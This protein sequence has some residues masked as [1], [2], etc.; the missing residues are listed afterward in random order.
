MA[1]RRANGEGTIYRRKDGRW[2]GA[3]YLL[4]T[5]GASKRIRIYGTSRSGVYAK[6]TEAKAK[7][8]QGIA[9]PDKVWQLGEYL[10]YW[11]E[12]IIKPH[13]RPTTYESYENKVRLYLKPTL[14]HYLLNRTSVP[15]LQSYLNSQLANGLSVRVVQMLREVLS[16]AL[17]SAMRQELVNRNVARLVQLPSRASS[18]VTPWTLNQATHFLK[19]AKGHWLYPAFVLLVIYGLRRGEVLGV[20]WTDIHFEHD[21]LHLEQQ[22]YRAN[23]IV[24]EGP[25]KTKSSRRKLPLVGIARD[26]LLAHQQDVGASQSHLVFTAQKSDGPIEPQTFTRSFQR[27]CKNAGL[28]ATGPHAMRHTA[29][30][31]LKNLGVPARDAQLIL[32]HS[33]IVTTQQIYQHD[34]LASR[35]DALERLERQ[36]HPDGNADPDEES[37]LPSTLPSNAVLAVDSQR[38]KTPS[39]RLYLNNLLAGVEGFEPPNAWTKSSNSTHWG[40]SLERVTEVRM[41]MQTRTRQWMLGCV[42][43]NL[44]VKYPAG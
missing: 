33:N 12:N 29:A 15:V 30:T 8:Q 19:A 2:E 18:D 42:A 22:I 7:Q 37:A 25:L 34:D 4:T 31:L 23:R 32:G 41:A 28:H 27:A 39:W 36:L 40:R 6:L 35:R 43:V 21:E 16:S 13:R 20:R 14:G 3:A 5:S 24:G 26:A 10:D 44:A 17:T 11:L 38:E 1:R 9:T